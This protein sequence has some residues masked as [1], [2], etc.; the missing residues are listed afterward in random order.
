MPEKGMKK[1]VY[2]SKNKTDDGKNVVS[3]HRM[4][5]GYV[6]HFAGSIDFHL[7]STTIVAYLLD[8]AYPYLVEILLRGEIFS[9]WLELH[10]ILTI[11]ALAAVVN[12]KALGFLSTNKSGKSGLAAALSQHGHPFLTDDLLPIENRDDHFLANRLPCN[13]D[14]V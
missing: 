3:I 1:L 14:V 13:A 12:D 5:D 8:P 9:I 7:S 4:D 10:G 2:A 11:H 6:F